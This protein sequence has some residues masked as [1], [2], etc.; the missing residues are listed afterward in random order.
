MPFRILFV[1]DDD[2]LSALVTDY[3]RKRDYEVE[4][5]LYGNDAVPAILERGP[6]QSTFDVNLAGQDGFQ[7]CRDA[8]EQ[9]DGVIIMVPARNKQFDEV[10]GPEFSADDRMHQS[11]EPRLL[12]ARIKAQSRPVT[13]RAAEGAQPERYTF[14][15]F[16]ISRANRSVKLPDGSL[17]DLTSAEFD[18][19]WALVRCAGEVVSR[20]ELMWQLRGIEF[21]G[22][23]RT[24]DGGISRLRRKLNDDAGTSRRIKTVRGKG[25]QFSK[26]AWD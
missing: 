11:G 22:L 23:D 25:Y 20:D 16:E 7:I 1:E 10:L 8:C 17:P 26:Q 24:I 6:D 5:V 21:D 3:L 12:L 14:G 18:L 19:L 13:T 2:R 4:A 15:K 9:F